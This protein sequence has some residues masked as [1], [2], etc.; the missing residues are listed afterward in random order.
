MIKQTV[1][2]GQR[3]IEWKRLWRAWF[4]MRL[5]WSA[6]RVAVASRFSAELLYKKGLEI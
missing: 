2:D 4:V 1:E 3:S 5:G 6:R